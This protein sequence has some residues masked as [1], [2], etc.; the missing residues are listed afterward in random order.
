MKNP[1]KEKIL[2]IFL[3]ALPV[4]F[5]LGFTFAAL[6]ASSET[7]SINSSKEALSF[8]EYA[9][10]AGNSN[11]DDIVCDP[12]MYHKEQ[13]IMIYMV[14]S[15][16]ES[17]GNAASID[18][19][20]LINDCSVDT[21]ECNFVLFLGGTSS[22]ALDGINSS[23]NSIIYLHE[24][25][26]YVIES[27]EL[28]NMGDPN[29][30]S[31]FLNYTYQ[32]FPADQY[33]L[34]LW[35]HGGGPINGYG[36]DEVYKDRLFIDEFKVAFENSPFKKSNKLEWIGFDACVMAGI[37]YAECFKDYSNYLISS[38]EVSSGAGWNYTVM[39]TLSEKPYSGEEAGKIIGEGIL[40]GMQAYNFSSVYTDTYTTSCVNL[41]N[42]DA[43]IN[44]FT[45]LITAADKKL[46]KN[47][48]KIISGRADL[49]EFGSLFSS[50]RS[51]LVDLVSVV[52]TFEDICPDETEK[53]KD[54]FEEF[55]VYNDTPTSYSNGISIY[56]PYENTSNNKNS[57]KRYSE[58]NFCEEYI[59]YIEN[60][61]KIASGDISEFINT[62]EDEETTEEEETTKEE[63][64]EEITEEKTTEE[65]TT[66]E[67]T[68][69]ETT[70]EETTEEE[71]TEAKTEK[72]TIAEIIT[73]T[74]ELITEIITEP[75]TKPNPPVNE[76]ISDFYEYK[77]NKGT[78]YKVE[79]SDEQKDIFVNAYGCIYYKDDED[80][81]VILS[82]LKNTEY[83]DGILSADFGDSL[84][85]LSSN[86]EKFPCYVTEEFKTDDAVYYS[87]PV[88]LCRT[89]ANTVFDMTLEGLFCEIIIKVDEE[90]PDGVVEGAVVRTADGTQSPMI[91]IKNGYTIYP[92]YYYINEKQYDENGN[93][94]WIFSQK[95]VDAYLPDKSPIIVDDDFKVVREDF[96]DNEDR[97]YYI[98]F[99]INNLC[100][101]SYATEYLE[102]K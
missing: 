77:K 41:Q 59:E 61:F 33:S 19:L 67:V 98:N 30:L 12:I 17:S 90:N 83:E 24:G 5:A 95:D 60:V 50:N 35:D 89:G 45:D 47:Y 87:T 29:T 96:S 54:A 16:L 25:M 91:E 38:Q 100:D 27:K 4:L 32:S 13:T 57:F 94:E 99:R 84:F 81:I 36:V 102:V 53:M 97:E 65:E 15:D 34:I 66:E 6:S 14:G 1:L 31:Y 49:Y 44:D 3:I 73:S 56:Y 80:K 20:E 62:E 85:S 68:E 37:E 22:W 9:N 74:T 101:Y 92:Y 55:I 10:K 86:G 48:Q 28:F 75:S 8:D 52:E 39:E 79:F 11:K 18:I 46:Y 88:V 51:N 71:T 2:K 58:Y 21:S 40:P 70:E 43:F 76:S 7:V 26:P 72:P 64:T 82:E 93:N 42:Y 78:K 69:E 63:T 23:V